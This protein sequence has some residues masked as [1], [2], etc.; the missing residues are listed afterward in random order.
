MPY[1]KKLVGRKCFLSPCSSEDAAK[2]AEWHNDLAVTI[3]LGNEAYTPF[4]LERARASIGDVLQQQYHVFSIVDLGTDT[5]IGRCGLFD[6]DHV[7]RCAM[8]GILIGEKSYW[9]KGYSQEATSLL[10]DYAFNLLSLNSIMLGTFSFNE[11]AIRCYE[12]VGF[13]EIG[14]RRQAR[15]IAG[16]R[17]DTV[18]MDI[19]AE[20][21]ESA[22]VERV[23]LGQE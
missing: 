13:R 4:S 10:L 22:Y 14:R 21:F 6:I 1:Y 3:P 20:E 23:L 19:L 5:L 8:L 18:L 15:I 12:K 2:W 7:N 11:R 9:D 17:Y 16:K